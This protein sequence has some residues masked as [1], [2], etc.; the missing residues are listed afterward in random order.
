V[1]LEPRLREARALDLLIAAL[2]ADQAHVVRGA[3]VP[4]RLTT[5]S[6]LVVRP[7]RGAPE[8]K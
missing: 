6:P 8:P 3:G 7:A 4:A 2:G 5:D 1:W